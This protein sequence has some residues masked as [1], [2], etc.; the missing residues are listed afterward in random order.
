MGRRPQT[1]VGCPGCDDVFFVLI[2]SLGVEIRVNEWTGGSNK[3]TR[4]NKY[5]KENPGCW[6]T[7]WTLSHHPSRNFFLKNPSKKLQFHGDVDTQKGNS[8]KVARFA[9]LQPHGSRDRSMW[10]TH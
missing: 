2:L 7:A 9:K 5:A 6:E 4:G 8:A 10:S 1:H 3:T